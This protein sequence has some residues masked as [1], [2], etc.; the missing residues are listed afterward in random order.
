MYKNAQ[1][2]AGVHPFSEEEFCEYLMSFNSEIKGSL[3]SAGDFLVWIMAE[4]RK[5]TLKK[6]IV[7]YIVDE[8]IF[9][10]IKEYLLFYIFKIPLKF[11]SEINL[12]HLKPPSDC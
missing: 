5:E 12:Q 8:V 4:P 3:C 10:F 1:V 7:D 6:A 2:P 11:R 9:L